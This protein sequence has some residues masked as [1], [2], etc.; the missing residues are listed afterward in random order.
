MSNSPR[1]QTRNASSVWVALLGETV[2]VGGGQWVL[3]ELRRSESCAKK[4]R[5]RGNIHTQVFQLEGQHEAVRMQLLRQ[6]AQRMT[7]KG[8]KP[9]EMVGIL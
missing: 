2:G 3:L 8:Q 4:G 1:I 9:Q 6:T 5:H 7:K